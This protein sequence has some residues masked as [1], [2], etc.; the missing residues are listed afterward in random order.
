[1]KS[2]CVYFLVIV[3]FLANISC[4]NRQFIEGRTEVI[5]TSDTLLNDS[6]IF[7]GHIS[8]VD[9]GYLYGPVKVWIENTNYKTTSDSVGNYALKT[10]PGTYTIKCQSK[11]NNWAQLIEE[12]KDIKIDKNQKIRIDFYL[13]YTVE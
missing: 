9:M 4:L 12:K 3:A 8:D 2:K 13:G 7:V 11:W 6:S 5:S 1:M 10:L